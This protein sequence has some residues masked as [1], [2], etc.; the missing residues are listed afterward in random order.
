MANI[1][2]N[3]PKS[4]EGLR[5]GLEDINT[6]RNRIVDFNDFNMEFNDVGTFSIDGGKDSEILI[7][8]SKQ[9]MTYYAIE[10]KI[11]LVNDNFN[12]ILNSEDGEL[13]LILFTR[14]N[15]ET[16]EYFTTVYDSSNNQW[17]YEYYGFLGIT[18]NFLSATTQATY[19]TIDMKVTPLQYTGQDVLFLSGKTLKRGNID[20]DSHVK[21]GSG[22]RKEDGELKLGTH[23]DFP[24]IPSGY[25]TEDT[26]L[27]RTNEWGLWSSSVIF[28]DQSTELL[29]DNGVS[30]EMES[31]SNPFAENDVAYVRTRMDNADNNGQPSVTIGIRYNEQEG[32]V[33]QDEESLTFSGIGNIMKSSSNLGIVTDGDY[34]DSEIIQ[35]KA[36]ASVLAVKKL[37]DLS[38]VGVNSILQNG[39]S[40]GASVVIGSN[41]TQDVILERNNVE[42]FKVIDNGIQLNTTAS[43]KALIG[44]GIS[45]HSIQFGVSGSDN[46]SYLASPVLNISAHHFGDIARFSGGNSGNTIFAGIRSDGRTYGANA[47]AND[48]FVPLGQLNLGLP[49]GTAT[50]DINGKVPLSQINDAL[51]GNVT[52]K[53][54]FD[55]TFITAS[56]DPVLVGQ[57]LPAP[58]DAKGWYF[59]ATTAFVNGGKDYATGDWIIS[60]ASQWDKVDNTDAVSSVNG[61]VG[62]V[63]I[64]PT[65][66]GLGNVDNTS[67][68]NKPISIATQLALNTK[69][70]SLSWKSPQDYGAVGNGIVDDTN[71]IKQCFL[72][73]KNVFLYG[74]YKITNF[75]EIYSDQFVFSNNATITR[76]ST[77]S[78]TM[79]ALAR[80]NIQIK[81]SLT[82]I[83]SGNSS[84]TASGITFSGCDNIKVD[85]VVFKDISGIALW[86]KSGAVAMPRGD[87]ALVSNIQVYNSYIGLQCDFDNQGEY[88]S[89][90][91][92]NATLCN[93]GAV[94]TA[95]NTS[96]TGG[97]IVDN[98]TGVNIGGLAGTNNSHGILNGVNINHNTLNAKFSIAENGHTISG[99]HFY[100][101]ATN[102]I[103]IVNSRGLNFTNCMIS[104]VIKNTDSLT[105]KGTH[106]F[107]ACT[108]LP[109]TVFSGSGKDTDVLFINNTTLTGGLWADNTKLYVKRT[110]ETSQS[111]AGSISVTGQIATSQATVDTN[112]PTWGQ[113]KTLVAQT[114]TNGVTTSAP[115]QDATYDFVTNQTGWAQYSDNVYTVG[116]PLVI[117][118]GVTTVLTNNRATA[119]TT[120]LPT[121]IIEFVNAASKITPQNS[122]DFYNIEVRFKAKSS[123]PSGRIKVALDIGGAM[124]I[125]REQRVEIA[126]GVGIEQLIAIPMMLFSG[127]TFVANGGSVTVTS[128]VGNTSIY[129]ITFVVSRVHKAK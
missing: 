30:V 54:L 93:T 51:I 41:D 1:K 68:L 73:N 23:Y 95:G 45:V 13:V 105:P 55:G 7:S 49:N 78:A 22:L 47:V 70:N 62:V 89:F 37:I 12:Q 84:G 20:I 28:R 128:L 88:H 114:I 4:G 102:N 110:G 17:R 123:S 34:S 3:I 50:L 56:P 58:F 14:D 27:I 109:L 85:G 36:Y 71:A 9:T 112:V 60:N 127:A 119:I 66:I 121:G 83:G 6:P 116:S 90:V 19:P 96:I 111:I 82:I 87:G 63:T 75:I 97:N 61:M 94:I 18:L 129:D 107:T 108:M 117:N 118:S 120:E 21:V 38:N 74:S 24:N 115:S 59:I 46:I 67:D 43:A 48:D 124:G 35:N 65:T 76:A 32:E 52:Y 53:G 57:F 72:E 101:D 64:T 79:V 25:I 40:F 42:I 8:N 44:S 15:V 122:G 81:G 104:G 106:S 86:F 126:D 80:N 26:D 103:E 113:A 125:I 91:N 16:T 69:Q 92:F 100:G 99:C 77:N 10:D 31:R 29:P 5:F 39:N 2:I 33:P 11:I 98:A